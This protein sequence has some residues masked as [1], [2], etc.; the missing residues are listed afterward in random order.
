M[1]IVVG[2]MD[3][4][5]KTGGLGHMIWP[6]GDFRADMLKI[7]DVYQSCTAKH[8]ERTARSID[9]IVGCDEEQEI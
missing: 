4:G 7:F 2:F 1:P 3:Y 9:D 8:P 5:K 6:T